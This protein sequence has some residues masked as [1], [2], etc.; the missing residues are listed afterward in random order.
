MTNT[1]LVEV[2]CSYYYEK[3]G[4]A[5]WKYVMAPLKSGE[6]CGDTFFYS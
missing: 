2:W 4:E 5:E 3:V 1:W 6:M